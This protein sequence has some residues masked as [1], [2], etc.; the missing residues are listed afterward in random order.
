MSIEQGF[1][2][3]AEPARGFAETATETV[4]ALAV[5]PE[6]DG[7]GAPDAE[8]IRAGVSGALANSG[9]ASAADLLGA[10]KWTVDGATVRIEVAGMGK[11]MLALTVNA[12]AEK[13]IRQELTRLG[14]PGRFLIVP[15][16]GA[17]AAA[18]PTAVKPVEGSIQAEALKHPMV[19]RAKEIFKAEVRSVLDLR[20]K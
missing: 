11:K 2:A 4:G 9:H 7:V 10:G 3:A 1:S 12:A 15:G 13:V 14:A 17:G 16:A 20:Q 19:E 8:T 18:V 5:A 6:V